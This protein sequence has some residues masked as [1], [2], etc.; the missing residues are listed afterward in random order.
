VWSEWGREENFFELGGHSLLATQV[1]SRVREAC[2]VEMEVRTLFEQPTVAQLAQVIETEL[3][4]QH[5]IDVPPLV[6]VERGQK[7]LP[8]FA[9]QRLWFL[10]QLDPQTV[11][12]NVPGAARFRGRLDVQALEHT[13]TEVVR[14]HEVLRTTFAMIEGELVQLIAPPSKFVLPVTDLSEL[15]EAEREAQAQSLARAEARQPF[16]LT[17]G[18]LLRAHLLRLADDEH[19]LLITMHHIVSDEWSLRLL[20]K[21]VATLYELF[22]QEAVS[23]LPE[24]PVQYADYAMW[25]R[26][27]LQGEVLQEELQYWRE[28]LAGAP[29][30]LELPADRPRPACRQATREM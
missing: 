22:I 2:G 23:P 4:K 15:N 12:Y 29:P 1:V 30:V 27:Y 18:P 16:N 9:Q 3:R 26:E 7:L 10:Q 24:L 13:L 19:Q 8:S 14:R 6:P 21:E 5:S 20:V 11:A 17:D 28:Q 25:Q